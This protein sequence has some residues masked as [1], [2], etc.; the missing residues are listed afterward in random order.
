M[1]IQTPAT[2][3]SQVR[4]YIGSSILIYQNIEII[5]KNLLTINN[6]TVKSN[7]PPPD[8]STLQQ[9]WKKQTM[10]MLVGAIFEKFF[11]IL[12]ESQPDEKDDPITEIRVTT[13]CGIEMN[14]GDRDN[15]LQRFSS[16]VD[17]RNNLVHHF[18][19]IY[20]LDN[21]AAQQKTLATLKINHEDAK[22]IRD[23]LALVTKTLQEAQQAAVHFLQSDEFSKELNLTQLQDSPTMQ[24][25]GELAFKKN[26]WG[27]WLPI[28]WAIEYLQ[29][30]GS[31]EYL[32]LCKKHN[33]KT[34]GDLMR[35]SEL[36]EFQTQP[37]KRG[38]RNVFR[39]RQDL[40]AEALA[41]VAEQEQK[42]PQVR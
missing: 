10:G 2:T 5:L 12:G 36:F 38:V 13:T 42:S 18:Y 26:H 23:Y 7:A 22:I 3:L 8:F 14:A 39:A 21:E 6:I 29:K 9:P 4:E 20:S 33:C 41:Y 40:V 30:N 15:W 27:D 19:E 35:V 25:L 11:H 17:S 24:L 34:L 16:L 31:N 1:D 37:T 28:S 32:A